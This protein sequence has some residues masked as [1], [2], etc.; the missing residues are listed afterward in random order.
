MPSFPPQCDGCL[1]VLDA[2][3]KSFTADC[4]KDEEGKRRS[5]EAELPTLPK[6]DSATLAFAEKAQNRFREEM[7]SR[8]ELA[9]DRLEENQK[10]LAQSSQQRITT[11]TNNV[12]A[13]TTRC[14]S[15]RHNHNSVKNSIF[16][17]HGLRGWSINR[18][19]RSHINF[20]RDDGSRGTVRK[21]T[22]YSHS[23]YTTTKCPDWDRYYRKVQAC[24]AELNVMPEKAAYENAKARLAELKD[25]LKQAQSEEKE[26]PDLDEEDKRTL[27]TKFAKLLSEPKLDFEGQK[28]YQSRV[29][30]DP[31]F[32]G[33]VKL[34]DADVRVL[35]ILSEPNELVLAIPVESTIS[36]DVEPVESGLSYYLFGTDKLFCSERNDTD[37]MDFS[38]TSKCGSCSYLVF[39]SEV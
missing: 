4:P 37:P 19:G 7:L 13:A 14:E 35:N 12:Q 24:S 2:R 36:I 5:I 1:D 6:L 39:Y 33:V 21:T 22:G 34:E 30:C 26:R 10:V 25:E 32:L 16:A 11:L 18:F 15:E 23:G 28:N 31:M 9:L 27:L 29:G 3:K 8:K 17:R 20:I 38:P